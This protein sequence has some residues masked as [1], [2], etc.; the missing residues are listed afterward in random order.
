MQKMLINRNELILDKGIITVNNNSYQRLAI[1]THFVQPS[2]SYIELIQRYV[3]PVIENE[4]ILFISE[5]IISICQNRIIHKNQ[6][7]PGFWAKNLSKFVM[8]TTAG[9]SVGNVYKMQTAIHLAGL[10]R[11]IF[12]AMCSALTKPFGIRGVFYRV[13]GHEINGIDG[14]YGESFPEYNE[15]GIL[16]P[17][18]PNQVCLNIFNETKINSIIVDAN[19]I[20]VNILGKNN[21]I[22]EGNK[23]II[24][25]IKDNPAGQGNECT[26]FILFRK[27]KEDSYEYKC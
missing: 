12:A 19:D 14:F 18:N 2:E 3:Q 21:M 1:K 5:K 4:D 8:K 7:K 25:M 6:V 9:Y 20:G 10:P 26:P 13:A 16:N 15:I 24:Q 22:L 17:S 27:L 23:E 11:I